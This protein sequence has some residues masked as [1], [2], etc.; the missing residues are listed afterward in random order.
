M[1][2]PGYQSPFT[3]RTIDNALVYAIFYFTFAFGAL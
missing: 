2:C 3:G 1:A